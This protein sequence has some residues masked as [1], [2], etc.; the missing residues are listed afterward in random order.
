[1]NI[2]LE[3]T[4]KDT[5]TA[6]LLEKAIVHD[7]GDSVAYTDG[8][9]TFINTEE[10]LT[11]LLPAYDTDMLKWLLWHEKYHMELRHHERYRNLVVTDS[12][13]LNMKAVNIIMDILVHDSLS[14]MFPELVE[15]ARKNLAQ[16]RDKNS[17]LYT[18]KTFTLEEM[19]EEFAEFCK[20]Q[21]SNPDSNSDSSGES[22]A[23]SDSKGKAIAMEEEDT[24]PKGKPSSDKTPEEASDK[25]PE[26]KDG[27]AEQTSGQE[28]DSCWEQLKTIDS[29]E[30]ITKMESDNIKQAVNHL[31]QVKLQL[32]TITKKLNSMVTVSRQRTYARPSYLHSPHAIIK[33]SAPG[34]CNLYFCFDAS[35][36]MGHELDIF[37]EIITKAV[38]QAMSVP[39]EW[40]SGTTPKIKEYQYD[41]YKGTFRDIIPV[42]A[43]SGYG[44][45]GDR[46]VTLCYQAEQKGFS[47]L[48]ITDG[49]GG[50]DED[51]IAMVKKLRSTIV[52]TH[53]QNFTAL[54]HKTNPR[55]EVIYVGV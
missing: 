15:T 44:N 29:R 3:K 52:V 39:T 55:L 24:A 2:F 14:K 27:K 17:L 38:P 45:D 50:L 48:C 6:L 8:D 16:M 49:G 34:R 33:G 21:A 25:A 32:A 36:S 22:D 47:P 40:F 12:C 43:S 30:F 42:Q 46:T 28:P 20:D 37:K 19:I 26:V 51:S 1:M 54:I 10:N 18:F 7:I 23:D 5:D 53:S 31:R 9:T 13:K 4:P 35:G 11:K 41:Y